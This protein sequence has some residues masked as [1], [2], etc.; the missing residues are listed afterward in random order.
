MVGSTNKQGKKNVLY[1]KLEENKSCIISKRS[2]K[3]MSVN[4]IKCH[5]IREEND[6]SAESCPYYLHHFPALN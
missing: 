6:T 3:W 5:Q 2:A 4:A 1:V